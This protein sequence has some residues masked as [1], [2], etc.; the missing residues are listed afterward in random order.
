MVPGAAGMVERAAGP[1]G[2]IKRGPGTEPASTLPANMETAAAI[3]RNCK[4]WNVRPFIMGELL[5]IKN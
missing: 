3:N 2:G 4:A 5:P 1:T